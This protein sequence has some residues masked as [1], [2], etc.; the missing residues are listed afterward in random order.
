METAIFR[1]SDF[2]KDDGGMKVVKDRFNKLGDDLIK[3]AKEVREKTKIIDLNNIDQFNQLEKETEEL[4]AVNKKYEASLKKIAVLEKKMATAKAKTVKGITKETEALRKQRVVARQIARIK[5]TEAGSIENLRAKLAL[6]TTAWTKLTA[7]EI[8]NTK[9]GRRL[10]ESK[11]Q[12]TATLKK[13]ERATNDNR[14]NV[15]NYTSAL[16]K[17]RAGLINL[18]SAGGL[19]LGVFGAFRLIRNMT[20]IVRDYEKANATLAGVLGVNKEE[21]IELREQS[22]SLGQTTVKTAQEVVTLQTAYARLGFTQ[23]EILALTEPTINGSIE[24]N[25]GLEETS[26]LVGAIVN[27][28]D[29][30][31]ATDA[32]KIMEILTA[33]TTKS[34]LTFEK[35]A[36]Q[37]PIVL[38]GANALDIGLSEVVGTL[39]KLADGGIEA[40]TGATALRNIYIE[41][42]KRGLNYKVALDKITKSQDKLTTANKIFGKRASISALVISNNAEGVAELT[43]ELEGAKVVMKLVDNEL[44]TLDGSLKLL[45][46]AWEGL[47]LKMSDASGAGNVMTRTIRSLAENMET[48]FKVMGIAIVTY[49]AYNVALRASNALT[50]AGIVWTKGKTI[51][52][53]WNTIATNTATIAQKA[54]NVAV[55]AN[56]LGVLIA[57][58][59]G[60]VTA[61]YFFRDSVSDAEK[62]QKQF[63]E[64]REEGVKSGTEAI[65]VERAELD[66]KTELLQQEIALRKASG[67]DT[68]KLDKEERERRRDLL[69][70]GVKRN[71]DLIDGGKKTALVLKKQLEDRLKSIEDNAKIFTNPKT[72]TAKLLTEDGKNI[73]RAKQYEVQI[74]KDATGQIQGVNEARNKAIAKTNQELIDLDKSLEL[75]QA[76]ITAKRLKQLELLRRRLEDLRNEDIADDENREIAETKTKFEREIKAITGN[77]AVEIALR[78]QLEE[79]KQAEIEKIRMKFRKKREKELDEL[80]LFEL[81]LLKEG[82]D[83]RIEQEKAKSQKVLDAIEESIKLT[84]DQKI[85][86]TEIEEQRATDAITKIQVNAEL[87]R[88]QNALAIEEAK[89]DQKKGFFK[90]EKEFEEFKAKELAKIQIENLEK[91]LAV[92]EQFQ[93]DAFDVQKEQ[94]KAQIAGL[95]SIFKKDKFEE[96]AEG[97]RMVVTRVFEGFTD[98]AR[99]E[100]EKSKKLLSDQ[101]K[102]VDAQRKRAEQGLENTLA[103]EQRELGKREADLIKREKRKERIEK[104]R[105]LYSSYNNYAS[106]GSKNPIAQ[107]LRDFAILEAIT[108]SFGKGGVIEDNLPTDGIFRGQS[109][110]GKQGGIPILVEGREGI[111]SAKEMA[112]LGKQNFYA[113]KDLASTGKI[114]SNFFTKQREGFMKAVPVITT[115]PRLIKEMREVKQAIENKPVQNWDVADVA[116][117][118]MEMV[119]TLMTKNK[120]IRNHYKTK[121]PRI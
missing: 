81:S 112:N 93:G 4:I 9:R 111:F 41:S 117:G 84:T 89:I 17:A 56:P 32:P 2:F 26:L 38:A 31:S 14:R 118:V 46:S 113:M 28:Y 59:A 80:E 53:N 92:L 42:A 35:L 91:Q 15:G 99:K 23:Q 69:I 100:V 39:G 1:Y 52:Q 75:D 78:K 79:T 60:A 33:G 116:D 20:R 108:A 50:K 30:L 12:L 58:L 119:E 114:D 66:E 97:I 37:L 83:K 61:Y 64:S 115:D 18:A 101:E 24:L 3:K 16:G 109:H 36:V 8:E 104:T 48:I 21:T 6:V 43:E 25:A 94:I 96:L 87:E 73:A 107:A 57:L 29:D 98:K 54:F 105:A 55:K 63:N 51:A 82:T 86:F 47:V 90:T 44:N 85:K 40:S 65:E 13:L 67:E 102:S 22:Q 19:M 106:R 103:F 45:R 7:K 62:A 72:G 88:L 74:F 76:E 5:N 95:K 10:N 70:E 34:A 120:T 71:Q 68:K 49:L 77:S 121:K 27:S 110:Q 11:K